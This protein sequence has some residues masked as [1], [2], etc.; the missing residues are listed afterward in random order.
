MANQENRL[1]GVWIASNIMRVISPGPISGAEG[2]KTMDVHLKEVI[3]ANVLTEM[4]VEDNP[5]L[6][7]S[8]TPEEI[9]QA[10]LLYT[11]NERKKPRE[12]IIRTEREVR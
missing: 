8:A 6:V 5:S 11:H 7:R 3:I 9:A 2:R 10:K 12:F 1:G 4:V